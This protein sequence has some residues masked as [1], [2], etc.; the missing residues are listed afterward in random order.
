M[1]L[2]LINDR[3]RPTGGSERTLKSQIQGL[4]ARGHQVLAVVPEE[5]LEYCQS[6]ETWQGVEW[7][8]IAHA[9]GFRSALHAAN[10]I[11]EQAQ[12]WQ[13][14]VLEVVNI[15]G[16]LG[17]TGVIELCKHLPVV[18]AFRDVRPTCPRGDRDLGEKGLCEDRASL[19]CMTRSCMTPQHEPRGWRGVLDSRLRLRALRS[20]HAVVTESHAMLE[21]L[22]KFGVKES[23]LFLPPLHVD[24]PQQLGPPPSACPPTILGL[25]LLSNP[26]KG[27]SHLLQAFAAIPN[28]EARLRLSGIPGAAW[29]QVQ[30]FVQQHNLEQRIEL[31]GW[32]EEEALQQEL[33]HCRTLAFPSRY[34]ESFGLAGAEASAH[35]RPVVASDCRGAHD[36]VKHQITG[37]I[38]ERNSHTAMADALQSYLEDPQLA[39]EHGVAGREYISQ[40]FTRNAM[41]DALELVYQ[42]VLKPQTVG[43]PK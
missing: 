1:R 7:F 41:I 9:A 18:H 2:M 42:S 32:L 37:Q 22:K 28:Q 35:A 13:A 12:A 21:L 30:D 5:E 20:A 19:R 43:T 36:W 29:K 27:L 34:F 11:R 17:P 33:S 14:D 4:I 16:L 10:L 31:L 6:A 39:D 38:V 25:G 24:L 23:R 15:G 40:R 8:S 26:T 3:L